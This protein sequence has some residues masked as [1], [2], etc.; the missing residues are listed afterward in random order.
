M[1]ILNNENAG[2]LKDITLFLTKE[3][4]TELKD[5]LERLIK[6]IGNN[7]QHINDI[8]YFRE[9]TVTLYN[10]NNLNH[11]DERSK[12]LKLEDV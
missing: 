8:E 2:P 1:R 12:K 9:L 10:P 3:E 5:D 7:E 6:N 11:F 4:A